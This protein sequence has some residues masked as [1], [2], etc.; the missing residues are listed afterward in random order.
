M[1]QVRSLPGLLVLLVIVNI[2]HN[3]SLQI[4][5]TRSP[6]ASLDQVSLAILALISQL[7]PH[8]SG[9]VA[10][11]HRVAGPDP[12]PPLPPG[13]LLQRSVQSCLPT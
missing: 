12:L 13:L 9:V 5:L 2:R 3:V 1:E 7:T 4:D 11:A 8:S 10:P 6:A